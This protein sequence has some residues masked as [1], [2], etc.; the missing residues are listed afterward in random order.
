MEAPLARKGYRAIYFDMDGTLLP[1][2]IKE[3]L[4]R[5]YHEL[6][7]FAAEHG[8]ESQRFIDAVNAGVHAMYT[9]VDGRTNSDVF[10]ERV[11]GD[12]GIED[13]QW[14]SLI[15]GFYTGPY[16]AIG[17]G[18]VP[19][20]AM[21]QAVKVLSDAGYPS[22]LATM[23]LFPRVAI[24]ERLRWAGI[25]PALF[26]RITD[27]ENSRAA[28]PSLAYYS[29]N[30]EALG[31]EDSVQGDVLMVG[32][33]TRDDLGAEH[34]GYDVYLVTDWLLDPFDVGLDGITHGTSQEFLDWVKT[35]PPCENP[36]TFVNDG[37]V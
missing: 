14:Q 7:Q 21:Q 33:D 15:M 20:A 12:L 28:K 17:N 19:N 27:Y 16:T 31:F 10:W 6:G 22:V 9:H 1:M 3:F 18:V 34:V 11:N 24:E 2:D 32:N 25:D 4:G 37:L 13:D 35:F 30:L 5:Y 26:G 29:E 36:A 8:I 23:P